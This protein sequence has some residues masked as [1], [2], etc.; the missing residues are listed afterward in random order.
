MVLVIGWPVAR[1]NAIIFFLIDTPALYAIHRGLLA[2]QGYYLH[3]R[4]RAGIKV[5]LVRSNIPIIGGELLQDTANL[6][7]VFVLFNLGVLI[8]IFLATL[9]VDAETRH[10]WVLSPFQKI[11][12]FSK[13]LNESTSFI[14]DPLTLH[15][16]TCR[17]GN[18][19][20]VQYW[21]AAYNESQELRFNRRSVRNAFCQAGAPHAQPLLGAQCVLGNGETA[22][23]LDAAPLTYLFE[24][25]KS[26]STIHKISDTIWL[27]ELY[28]TDFKESTSHPLRKIPNSFFGTS[29]HIFVYKTN[30]SDNGFSNDTAVFWF[31]NSTT[32]SWHFSAGQIDSTGTAEC[33]PPL[34]LSLHGSTTIDTFFSSSRTK[35]IAQ[36]IMSSGIYRMWGLETPAIVIFERFLRESIRGV[37]L[38]LSTPAY[39]KMPIKDYTTLSTRS[40]VLYSTVIILAILLFPIRELL[41]LFL[42]RTEKVSRSQLFGYEYDQ[43]SR[44]LRNAQERLSRTSQPNEYAILNPTDE[45]SQG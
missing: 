43:M 19:T 1:V 8:C 16:L 7:S 33:L 20:H 24:P 14:F 25:E 37:P 39:V 12:I 6:P 45:T 36:F 31:H 10:P 15:N 27:E 22:C 42:V 3:T 34:L 35:N 18:E 5:Q 44:N 23:L 28:Y 9:G 11:T 32:N 26:N 38:S 29:G 2:L 17:T 4:V 40:I 41:Y 13:P 21:K 30:D